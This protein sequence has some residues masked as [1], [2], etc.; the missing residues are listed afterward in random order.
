MRNKQE[1]ISSFV[2]MVKQGCT[3]PEGGLCVG[4]IAATPK[5]AFRQ[6]SNQPPEGICTP[7]YI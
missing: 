6:P 7:A 5:R 1:E 4:L 2:V 3:S